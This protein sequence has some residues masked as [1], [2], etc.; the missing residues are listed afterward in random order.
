[1]DRSNGGCSLQLPHEYT[2]REGKFIFVSDFDRQALVNVDGVDTH[3]ALLKSQGPDVK[4][5]GQLGEH[6]TY[7]YT[8][9][10]IDVE[11]DYVVTAGCPSGNASYKVTHYDAILTLKRGKAHKT[12]VAKAVCGT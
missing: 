1:M 12:V 7:S 4:Q 8:G 5:R 6:S 10:N 11:V 9:D 2:N 3:L